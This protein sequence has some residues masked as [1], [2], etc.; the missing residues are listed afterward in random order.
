MKPFR[1]PPDFLMG[2]ATSGAQIEGGDANSNWYAWCQQGK[3]KDQTTCF[4]ANDHWNRYR[5]DIGLMV[6]LNHKV[7]RMGIEWSRIE[8]AEG[9]FNQEVLA[10]YRDEITLLLE[11]GI[12]PLV[13]LHHFSHPIWLEER[14]GFEDPRILTQFRH[15]VRYVVEGLGDLVSEFI[16]INEPNVYAVQGYYFGTWPPA[17][18]NIRL[19]L[20]VMKNMALC[21]ISAYRLIHEI[22]K[23]KG[24]PGQTMVGV[25]NHMRI[26]DPYNKRNP[27][28]RMAAR[29]MDYLFQDALTKS[30]AD[31]CLRAPLGTG[32][33]LGKGKFLDFFG[34][35]YYTRDA[36]R[37]RGFQNLV[38]PN[39]PVNDLGWEIYPEGL[40]RLC[41]RIYEQ[42]RVPIWITENG[43]CDEN[44]NFRSRYIYEH[45]RE[46]AK[47]C[48][49]GIPIERY[50]HWTLMDNF[51][52]AE[53]ESARFGL[54]HVDYNT[55]KRTI[56]ESGSFYAQ[57]C[58]NLEVSNEMI[59]TYLLGNIS[60]Q[61]P[62]GSSM[63]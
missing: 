18:K 8:P 6:Q 3:I 37:F 55:Q 50:Y 17:N 44:D 52:W 22:R 53:G 62:S 20:R 24:W 1:L 47:L 59:Q 29:V 36:V 15:Y 19:A 25:A 2:S 4:R 21:H 45:L 27:L 38:M 34:L 10:H 61:Y 39:T 35:N 49:N 23:E 58:K 56:R 30:M 31:G 40:S 28:D 7:Y 12:Q 60:S 32:A 5:E 43:T 41:T 46:V 57:I 14:G 26:F 9:Q 33:P 63:K 13:T 42:Y 48:R 54:I 16:T 51:E 11:K